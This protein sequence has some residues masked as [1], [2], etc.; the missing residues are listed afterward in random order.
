[1]LY[2]YYRYILII[3][4]ALLLI[5]VAILWSQRSSPWYNGGTTILVFS[6][7]E[8]FDPYRITNTASQMPWPYSLIHW[9]W[10]KI[11]L[12]VPWTYDTWYVLQYLRNGFPTVEHELTETSYFKNCRVTLNVVGEQIT[13][14]Q[15]Q[16]YGLHGQ[17][18]A[19]VI[20]I[21]WI[22]L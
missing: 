11:T 5:W 19:V 20:L 3:K 7:E 22:I 9:E 12:H 14:S 18:W 8:S 4:I 13:L 16:K 1:M 2:K 6:S 10:Q 21:I 17:I 15:C